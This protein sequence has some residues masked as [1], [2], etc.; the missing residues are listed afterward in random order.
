MR[1]L[2]MV[3]LRMQL[4]CNKK[5]PCMKGKALF[6]ERNMGVKFIF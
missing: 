1:V 5:V 6:D 3:A 4:S 2:R